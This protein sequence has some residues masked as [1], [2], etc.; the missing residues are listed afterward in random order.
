MRNLID[1][2]PTSFTTCVFA[3]GRLATGRMGCGAGTRRRIEACG[4]WC[5]VR[6]PSSWDRLQ[7]GPSTK[8][9]AAEQDAVCHSGYST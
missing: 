4:D 6:S 9:F 5:D 8:V 7:T 1:V 2:V 3:Q